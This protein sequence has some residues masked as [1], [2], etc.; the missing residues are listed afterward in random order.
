MPDGPSNILAFLFYLFI[1]HIGLS[2][3]AQASLEPEIFLTSVSQ[4]LRLQ[5]HASWPSST[6][7]RW[8]PAGT[9]VLSLYLPAS[10][11]ERPLN[12]DTALKG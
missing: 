5:V 12:A 7:V 3:I 9:S 6:M 8:P 4:E 11:H 1:F 10:I 2:Y